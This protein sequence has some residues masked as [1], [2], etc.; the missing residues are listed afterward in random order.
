MAQNQMQILQRLSGNVG[1]STDTLSPPS[2][3]MENQ[4]AANTSDS[5]IKPWVVYPKFDQFFET[6]LD[7]D[8]RDTGSFLQKLNDIAIYRID[9][10]ATLTDAE[11]KEEGFKIG[12]I[13][14]LRREVEKALKEY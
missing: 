6:L 11:M 14:W 3:I 1:Y 13:K 8:G 9:E 7:V 4:A 10:L 5:L 12:D 2:I